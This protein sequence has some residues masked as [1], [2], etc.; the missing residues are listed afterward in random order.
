VGCGSG[1]AWAL[2]S[3]NRFADNIS[4]LK[5]E[6]ALNKNGYFGS[7][8]MGRAHTR[9]IE[10]NNPARTAAKFAGLASKNPVSV[11]TI[12]GKGVVYRM[13]DRSI[14]THRYFSS[15]TDGSPVVE[16]KLHNV[17]GV[18]SQKI[19]FAKKGK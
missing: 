11:A 3:G 19:H 17:S 9:N 6:F 8:G 2:K 12:A 7:R 1:G 10:S 18:K 16:L 5:E 14:I 13:R 15:S 4:N